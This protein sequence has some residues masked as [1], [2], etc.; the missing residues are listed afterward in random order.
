MTHWCSRM[1]RNDGIPGNVVSLPTAAAD[2]VRQGKRSKRTPRNVVA[3]HIPEPAPKPP[4]VVQDEV[5]TELDRATR[6]PHT[7][8]TV[9]TR[10]VT[11]ARHKLGLQDI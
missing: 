3:F 10:L 6:D 9:A 7:A 5:A 2:P 8:A 1:R 4:A 11:M